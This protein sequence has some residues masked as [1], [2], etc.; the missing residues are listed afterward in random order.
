MMCV[1]IDESFFET[2]ISNTSACL[3]RA[4]CLL[5]TSASIVGVPGDQRILMSAS[6]TISPNH[7]ISSDESSSSSSSLLRHSLTIIFMPQLTFDALLSTQH[8]GTVLTGPE[9]NQHRYQHSTLSHS[10]ENNQHRCDFP[11]TMFLQ[12]PILH[13][14][15]Q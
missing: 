2:D 15:E 5:K 7:S 3:I 13:P 4:F 12:K 6:V 1:E 10:A 9:N 8:S 11:S 14:N